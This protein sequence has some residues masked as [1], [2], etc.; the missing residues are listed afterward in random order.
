MMEEVR[1][2]CEIQIIID[3]F[4]TNFVIPDD[5]H[6]YVNYRH[7]SGGSPLCILCDRLGIL[8]QE[9]KIAKLIELGADVNVSNTY[10][11]ITPLVLHLRGYWEKNL[12][13]VRMMIHAGT[14]V[15]TVYN[16]F[17]LHVDPTSTR[18]YVEL[19][20]LS[21]C[22]L[23]P[24]KDSKAVMYDII[25]LLLESGANVNYVNNMGIPAWVY[26]FYSTLM[27]RKITQPMSTIFLY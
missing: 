15:N 13:I 11:G 8:Q 24:H 20:P 9:E 5:L 7:R 19:C 1:D 4:I 22:I 25:N 16:F 18:E 2:D 27:R 12:N 26:C 6:L 10:I 21:T 17:P 14:N 3:N 23:T